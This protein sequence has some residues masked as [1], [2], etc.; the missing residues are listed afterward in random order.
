VETLEDLQKLRNC[1]F[2][3][4]ELWLWL[5][6]R[7]SMSKINQEI[8][9]IIMLNRKRNVNIIYTSQLHR[10]VDVLLWDT[11]QY[12]YYPH[13][14]KYN[15]DKYL[16]YQVENLKGEVIGE[17]LVNKPISY[18]KNHYDTYQEIGTL[19][20]KNDK[21]SF[22]EIGILL[23][24]DFVKA[25]KKL[26]I[27]HIDLLPHSGSHTSWMFDVIVWGRNKTLAFDVK[28]TFKKDGTVLIDKPAYQLKDSI[29]NAM[30][31]NAIPYI[32]FP[33]VDT[34]GYGKR[35]P[36][37]W[38]AYRL[39]YHSHILRLKSNKVSFNTMK[40]GSKPLKEVLKF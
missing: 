7:S 23:E 2:L 16:T 17:K 32:V 29:T 13:I 26:G 35:N 4:D 9:K 31:H 14:I 19:S 39:G 5:F 20:D 33:N 24:Q 27:K 28:T 12:F 36:S 11:T 18:W 38:F 3:G 25:V 6:A 1:T 34:K 37:N 8:V 22:T 15:G 10:Q 40:K 30:Q 21:K